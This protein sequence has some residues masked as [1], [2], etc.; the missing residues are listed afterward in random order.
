MNIVT[1]IFILLSFTIVKGLIQEDAAG[2]PEFLFP[3]LDVPDFEFQDLSAGCGGFTD[4]IEFVGYVI[5]NIGLGIIFLVL[6]LINLVVYIFDILTL[7]IEINFTGIEGAPT[8]INAI[9]ALPFA[10]SIAIIIFKLVR[11]GSSDA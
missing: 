8:F 10:A 4:C 7:I 2:A 6:L 9:L 1:I 11:K 5:Y 3:T